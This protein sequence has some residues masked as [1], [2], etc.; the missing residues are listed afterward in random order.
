MKTLNRESKID[1]LERWFLAHGGRIHQS[2][3]IA[4][5]DDAGHHLRVCSGC[6]L[7][8]MPTT[9]LVFC[10][11]RLSLSLTDIDPAN[12][13]WPEPFL[14]RF[15]DAPEVITRFLLVEQYCLGETSFWWPYLDM[16]PKP[17]SHRHPEP[18]FGTPLWFDEKDLVWLEGTNLGAARR[19]RE[20]A[21]RKE[22]DGGM[23]LL[24]ADSSRRT[25]LT[26]WDWY[27]SSS[28]LE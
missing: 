3:M 28:S 4:H 20:E 18:P 9:N 1:R 23:A 10:P 25:S 24:S 2:L 15:N 8:D 27:V 26:Q 17:P 12:S 19:L 11:L 7:P 6:E 22:F 13:H 5:D 21:W 14:T 16:L